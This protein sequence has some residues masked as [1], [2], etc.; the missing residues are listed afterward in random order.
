ML[1][2]G[3]L[4]R[5]WPVILTSC[6]AGLAFAIETWGAKTLTINWSSDWMEFLDASGTALSQGDAAENQ[7]GAALQLGYFTEATADN[8]F[9]GEWKHLTWATTSGDTAD[10]TGYG[11]GTFSFTVYFQEGTR[12]VQVYG[13]E[14]DSGAY[15]TE[16]ALAITTSQPSKGTY[17]AIRF[18]NHNLGNATHYNTIASPSWTGA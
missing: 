6:L 1:I 4:A 10:L 2:P 8:L 18:F 14:R 12:Y 7:D 15:K 17:L 16:V 3:K 11:D 13:A 9:A 5:S